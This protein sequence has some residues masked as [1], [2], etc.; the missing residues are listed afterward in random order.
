MS[1][2]ASQRS[3][4]A[5][6]IRVYFVSQPLQPSA[7]PI[8]EFDFKMAAERASQNALRSPSEIESLQPPRHP[9]CRARLP[10]DIG[11]FKQLV[12]EYTRVPADQIDA[13][14][15]RIVSFHSQL[16]SKRT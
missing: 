13:H 7:N 4:A 11:P 10:E 8:G 5:E 9:R 16:P 3:F 14:I 12:Q 15:H 6:H 2:V 1:V